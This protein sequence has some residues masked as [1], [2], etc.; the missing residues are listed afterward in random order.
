[1]PKRN[2]IFPLILVFFLGVFLTLSIVVSSQ[3]KSLFSE[4]QYSPPALNLTSTPTP[5]PICRDGTPEGS[6]C[7]SGY[8]CVE[9]A[10]VY[11]CIGTSCGLAT[12]TSK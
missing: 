6:C 4:A 11:L 5:V 9:T 12:S 10:G 1:M 8:K 3:R 7:K 2:V